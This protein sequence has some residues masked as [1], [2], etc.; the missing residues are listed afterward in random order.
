MKDTAKHL[1]ETKEATINIIS[2]WFSEAANFTSTGSPIGVS[3][4][5]LSGL[6]KEPSKI[7]RPP[8]VAESAFSV[9]A[10]V[11]H[12]IPVY[13]ERKENF[14]GSETFILQAVRV[15]VREDITNEDLT[16]INIGNLKP[17]ARLGG[18]KYGP[19][20]SAYELPR[21]DYTDDVAK[22][23]SGSKEKL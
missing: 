20:T 10:K 14:V 12:V 19:I 13:S 5:E 22:L 18:V 6:T 16:Q 8:L 17:V 23:A 7:V 1:N 9:E 21:P 3:E 2:E 15:H 11:T 4:W